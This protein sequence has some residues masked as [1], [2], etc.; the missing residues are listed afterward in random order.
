LNDRA[1]GDGDGSLRHESA[2]DRGARLHVDRG[3]SHTFVESAINE[4][5]VMNVAA[6]GLTPM[7]PVM[8]ESGTVDIPLFAS[9]T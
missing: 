9:I 2:V 7:F 4:N 3:L 1:A 8:A 5:P 6:A